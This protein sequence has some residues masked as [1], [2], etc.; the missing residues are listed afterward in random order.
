MG[1]YHRGIKMREEGTVVAVK[2]EAVVVEL[3]PRGG[4]GRCRLCI[5]GPAGMM[6][7]EAENKD[8][9]GI[10]D[11]VVL[12]IDDRRQ[13]R[14]AFL[15]YIL[16]VAGFMAGYAVAAMFSPSEGAGLAAGLSA[17]AGVYLAVRYY[18]RRITRRGEMWRK[19]VAVKREQEEKV[20]GGKDQRNA[21]EAGGSG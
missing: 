14:A 17:L 8:R 3:A 16:P 20:E 21:Q 12:D 11:R 19:V 1:F 13:L 10:G 5:P 7:V 15:V 4:C 9:A 2:G 18:D 6:R